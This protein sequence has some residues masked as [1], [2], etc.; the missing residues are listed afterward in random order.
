MK[1]SHSP[2]A[3]ALAAALVVSACSEARNPAAHRR[4]FSVTAA[5]AITYS[6]RATVVQAG[7]L[8]QQINL[9]DTGPLPP[10]GGAQ[11]KSLLDATVPGLLSVVVLHASTVG[12]GNH[13]RSEASVAQLSLAAGGNTISAGFL[14]ARAE[15]RGTDRGAT[16]SGSSEIAELPINNASIVVSG[17][18]N[19]TILRPNGQE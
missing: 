17:A 5:S 12:E 14:M 10:E 4:T 11:E 9:G 2:P 15:A 3:A 8:G 16:S 1:L 13:S 7:V 19:Q 6:G 18:P